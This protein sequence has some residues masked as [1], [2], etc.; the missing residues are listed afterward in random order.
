MGEDFEKAASGWCS[1]ELRLRRGVEPRRGGR[2]QRQTSLVN[3]RCKPIKRNSLDN[4][5]NRH[6]ANRR[7]T[8]LFERRARYDIKLPPR[9]V[10]W[11]V[12]AVRADS[13]NTEDVYIRV[14]G[15]F[16]RVATR[17]ELDA[18]LEPAERDSRRCPLL[19]QLQIGTAL[20]LNIETLPLNIGNVPLDSNSIN[21]K[22][23]VNEEFR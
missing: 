8:E 2:L 21:A 6:Q 12:L 19:P 23:F 17:G 11:V 3:L 10:E 1:Q 16:V 14:I 4:P 18:G 20:N 22:G 13:L 5:L 7:V 9:D 15:A